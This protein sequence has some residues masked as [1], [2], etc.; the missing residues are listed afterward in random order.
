[1]TEQGSKSGKSPLAQ[2]HDQYSLDG[3]FLRYLRGQIRI[4]W[5]RMG[6][7]TLVCLMLGSIV[8]PQV[9]ITALLVAGIAEIVDGLCLRYAYQRMQAG[10]SGQRFRR[11]TTVTAFLQG[12][13][14]CIGAAGPF[15]GALLLGPT[16][17]PVFMDP[18]FTVGLLAGGAINAGLLLPY[19]R[20]ATYARLICYATAPILLLVVGAVNVEH[21][22]FQLQLAGL[23]VL[24]GALLWYLIFVAR[25]F[26]HSRSIL[27]TQALQQQ[28]LE[29]AY[30]RL[31]DQQAEARKLA[32]VA[33]HANDSILLVDKSGKVQWV[34]E[35]FTQITGYRFNEVLGHDP[36]TFLNHP[37]TD[38][39]AIQAINDGRRDGRPF[40]VEILNKHKDGSGIWLETN[41]VPILDQDGGSMSYIAIERDITAAKQNAQHLEEARTAAEEGDRAKSDFLATMSHEIR[42]PMNGVIG[43]AQLL[44]ETRLD[45]EQQLYA[46]TILSSARTL[47]ALINDILDLSKLDAGEITLNPCDFDLHRC[48]EETIRLLRA[49][50]EIKGLELI[51]ERDA[52]VPQFL[53]GDDHRLR[54][55]LINLVGN[56]I[57]FTEKGRVKISLEAETDTD[58]SVLLTCAIADTG[59]GIATE[60]LTGIFERF[61]QADAAISRRFGGSGLGLAISRRLAEAMGGRIAVTS[62]LGAGSCFTIALPFETASGAQI[63]PAVEAVGE[64]PAVETANDRTEVEAVCKSDDTE[65]D[66]MRV[67]VAEDNRVNRLLVQKFLKNAPIELEFAK[68]GAEAVDLAKRFAPDIILMDISMPVMDGLE[69]THIIRSSAHAQPVIIALTA[70]AFDT[71]REAC[72]AVGMNEFVTKPVNRNQLLQ[73]L[74][75]YSHPARSQRTG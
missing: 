58:G 59:I 72:L 41:Q 1:M 5:A 21:M 43:M 42:T 45:A 32:L 25:S 62:Q 37:D 51:F 36:G 34:N 50:A 61:S 69:A 48:F 68:D 31:L 15:W 54:Q 33:R 23:L 4:F 7:I 30:Q 57:K 35:A 28:E 60:M 65:L 12:I 14:M 9:G 40:R 38:L 22:D 16:T 66:G 75:D 52:D 71:D 24:Y 55:I 74:R 73:V 64:R 8:A 49:Q 46:D 53:H 3:L 13:A 26:A 67:L 2:H 56:A 19:H 27:L 20:W 29:G 47:L 39:Q 63:L 70:N 18:L 11:L 6:F 10:E 17:A 44:E